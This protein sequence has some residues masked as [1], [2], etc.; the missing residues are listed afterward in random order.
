M[1]APYGFL[2]TWKR[3][4]LK[5]GRRVYSNQVDAKG[6][7]WEQAAQWIINYKDT[8]IPSVIENWAI[9]KDTATAVNT[10]TTGMFIEVRT[11]DVAMVFQGWTQGGT[12]NGHRVYTSRL[13]DIDNSYFTTDEA[14]Y[15]HAK[16]MCPAV[17][18][19]WQINKNSL[20]GV[21]S[22]IGEKWVRVL[23]TG[24]AADAT[25][26][27]SWRPI[28]TYP[29]SA[30]EADILNIEPTD[31]INNTWLNYVLNMHLPDTINGMTI[32]REKSK[33]TPDGKK[34]IAVSDSISARIFLQMP[35]ENKGIVD[36]RME[37]SSRIT[38]LNPSDNWEEVAE[39]MKSK[40][41]NE[42]DGW[43]INKS[44]TTS[45]RA[46]NGGLY[47]IAKSFLMWETELLDKYTFDNI[48]T[49]RGVRNGTRYYS[50]RINGIPGAIGTV[51][52]PTVDI[53]KKIGD[54]VH[55]RVPTAIKA[56]DGKMYTV[57]RNDIT[58]VVSALSGV[59]IEVGTGAIATTLEGVSMTSPWEV[60]SRGRLSS[61]I[62]GIP[63]GDVNWASVG[64]SMKNKLDDV[65]LGND[66][67]FYRIVKSSAELFDRGVAGIFIEV[68]AVVAPDGPPIIPKTTPTGPTTTPDTG[69]GSTNYGTPN[70]PVWKGGEGTYSESNSTIPLT[71]FK[72][73]IGLIVILL[74]FDKNDEE[75]L[76]YIKFSLATLAAYGLYSVL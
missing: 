14:I 10:G 62:N 43:P 63:V 5:Y 61:R 30:W 12:E 16:L 15:A 45:I 21:N 22:G 33:I 51:G 65:V 39:S 31:T 57:N 37:F 74:A 41:P 76:L 56:S 55:T 60:K 53:W 52:G 72:M 67:T 59:W 6:D 73:N 58:T 1:P 42:I 34:I 17:I 7:W 64:E 32:N 69:S 26:K 71:F 9:Q 13:G 49:E 40:V 46:S 3:N 18:D 8:T 27:S 68:D 48:W 70:R 29:T 54:A 11:V 19:R 75:D 36:N 2:G 38:G 66:G 20:Y 4:G 35:W 44:V 24:K 28:D 23:T 25:T 50:A 47:I